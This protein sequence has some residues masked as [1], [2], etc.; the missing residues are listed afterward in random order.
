M[1][2]PNSYQGKPTEKGVWDLQQVRDKQLLGTGKWKYDAPSA[3]SG[4]FVAGSNRDGVLG[5]NFGPQFARRSSPMQIGTQTDWSK[6]FK[7]M[8]PTVM[9]NAAMRTEGTLYVWGT[10]TYGTL[11]KNDTSIGKS[12][13]TQ[14]PG[15][16]WHELT[17]IGGDAE[18]MMASKTDGSLWVWGNNQYGTLGLNEKGGHATAQGGSKKKSS[19][20]QLGATGAWNVNKY[21]FSGVQHGAMAIGSNGGYYIWGINSSGRLGQNQN[22]GNWGF[23]PAGLSSPVQVGTEGNW[24]SVIMGGSCGGIKTDG[25][26]W[27]WGDQ[28]RG[29]AGQNSRQPDGL[30]SPCQVPGGNWSVMKGS[31]V[32]RMATKTD[33]TLW[34]WGYDAHGNLGLN[35][36]GTGEGRSSP[37]QVGSPSDIV[38]W[39]TE[40]FYV[41]A[42]Y[43]VAMKQDGSVWGC[44]RNSNGQFGN[45][46]VDDPEYSSPVQVAGAGVYYQLSKTY[47]NINW[48]KRDA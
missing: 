45:N 27:A 19:P 6:L 44:G 22:A 1:T 43:F 13:P 23:A 11:G 24:Q 31:D 32:T 20:T 47:N 3:P 15:T 30:S 39:D 38:K 18:G 7:N 42:N 33:G 12:S 48:L 46:T 10:N 2:Y 26:L 37:C 16:N 28:Y 4:L 35:E 40:N 5:G 36:Q 17:M 34:S 25:T 21:K 9:A 29:Q 41:G 8:G 14:I